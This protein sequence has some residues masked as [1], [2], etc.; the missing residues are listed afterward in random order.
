MNLHPIS[1]ENLADWLDGRLDAAARR[2]V[3][4]HLAQGCR[5]CATDLAWLRRIQAAARVADG[6]VEPPPQ[7]VERVKGLVR[8]RAVRPVVVPRV[9]PRAWSPR[10]ALAL[11]AVAVLLV[12]A[13][14]LAQVP[15]LERGAVLTTLEGAADLRSVGG[16]WQSAQAG[17]ELR[18]G[19]GLRVTQGTALLTL[20]DGSVLEAHA[21][22]ELVL[23]ALSASASAF[24]VRVAIDQQAGAVGYDVAPLR[25]LFSSF[26]V[27]SPTALV[28]VRGTRFVVTIENQAESRVE[29]LEGRVVVANALESQVLG[30]REV[31]LIQASA[32]VVRL[33]TLTPAPTPLPTRTAAPTS[34]PMPTPTPTDTA[35][36]PAANLG[37]APGSADATA[38][39]K[40]SVTSAAPQEPTATQTGTPT[41]TATVTPAPGVVVFYGRIERMPASRIGLWL[42]GGRLVLVMRETEI[43]GQPALGRQARVKARQHVLRPLEAIR[44]EI[45][46]AEP[47]VTPSPVR[48]STPQATPVIGPTATP[49]STRTPLPASTLTGTATAQPGITPE[50]TATP[51]PTNVHKPTHTPLATATPLPFRTRLPRPTDTPAPAVTAGA[52]SVKFTGTIEAFPNNLIGRWIIAGQN[53]IVTTATL[54]IG[55]PEVGLTADVEAL[56]MTSAAPLRAVRIRIH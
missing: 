17:A 46:R 35:V 43:V 5:M 10:W 28:Q 14:L 56:A 18:V 40:P 34:T 47:S 24:G 23:R 32:P 26:R 42:I 48:T 31:A 15:F 3:E 2:A 8:A 12:G 16:N 38:T 22:A 21:G 7:V 9:R 27:Q 33:P 45:A 20:F 36:T 41:L 4:Q 39:P 30:Q 44:I 52:H 54:I 19:E 29:V 49:E 37:P 55:R 13:G 53:V 11:A 51:V 6:A 50:E 1:F 25:G